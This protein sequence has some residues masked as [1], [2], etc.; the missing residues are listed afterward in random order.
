[1]QIIS[2]V[3]ILFVQT[4]PRASQLLSNRPSHA[5][6]KRRLKS[7]W[8]DLVSWEKRD[9][10][11][12]LFLSIA[13]S[14]LQQAF[15]KP[16]TLPPLLTTQLTTTERNQQSVSTKFRHI[17]NSLFVNYLADCWAWQAQ[18]EKESEQ[19]RVNQSIMRLNAGPSSWARL[20]TRARGRKT[21]ANWLKIWLPNVYLLM[22]ANKVLMKIP[23][24][25]ELSRERDLVVVD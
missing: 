22:L 14:T 1:M 6:Q 2:W 4:K 20:R 16:A 5:M 10:S 17:S 11:L 7:W 23:E 13:H 9:L 3:L 24:L 19:K 18:K 8:H 21:N 12:S 25:N 15:S